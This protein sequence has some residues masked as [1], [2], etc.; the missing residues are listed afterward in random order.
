MPIR[1]IA[2]TAGALL[3]MSALFSTAAPAFAD[4]RAAGEGAPVPVAHRGAS[5]YAPENTLAAVDKAAELGIEWVENDVQ[6]TRDGELVVMHDTTLDRTTDAEEVF[7][8]RAP[9][10]VADF[11]ADE[12]ARLDAGSWFGE[13]YAGAKV[14]TLKQYLDRVSAHDQKLLLELKK[15]ELYPGIE[16]ETL[17]ELSNEGWLDGRHVKDRLV[18]QSFNAESV[19]R[20]HMRKPAVKTGFL[21]TP[22]TS[23]LRKYGRFTD[24]INPSHTT[25][26]KD[27]VDAVH[28]VR[29]AHGKPLEVFTWTVNDAAGARA[30]ADA[31]VDGIISNFPDVVRDAVAE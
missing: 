8:D 7:P 15:P 21:G 28:D 31:G 14:P 24:Q 11:T 18:I 22:D 9:W 17:K 12:I 1:P 10:N 4:S 25:V 2:V 13:G 20:V 5:G 26:S 27:Y 16:G 3:G 30:A 19:A 29:G 6:R 23:D